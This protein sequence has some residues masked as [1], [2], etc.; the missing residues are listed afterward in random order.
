MRKS[1]TFCKNI[2]IYALARQRNFCSNK[3]TLKKSKGV[4]GK[5][6]KDKFSLMILITWKKIDQTVHRMSD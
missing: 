5:R 2:G 6:P 4:L 3:D 1:F